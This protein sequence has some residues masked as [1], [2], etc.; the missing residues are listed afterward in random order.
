MEYGNCP[1]V[2]TNSK[3]GEKKICT[4]L[5]VGFALEASIEAVQDYLHTGLRQLGRGAGC[6]TSPLQYGKI[7]KF[8]SCSFIPAEVNF[9]AYAKELMRLFD[10]DVPI[11]IKRD[12]V[13]RRAKYNE[14]SPG[15]T[16]PHCFTQKI[17]ARELIVL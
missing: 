7:V 14:R 2:A 8:G 4:R 5:R 3:P 16:S 13:S 10:F 6:Y 9:S 17:H 11:G 15:V 1:Y 12:W